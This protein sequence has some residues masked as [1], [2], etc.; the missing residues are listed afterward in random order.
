MENQR[1]RDIPKWFRKFYWWG[2]ASKVDLERDTKTIIVQLINHGAWSHWKWLVQTYGKEKLKN[3]I[4]EIPTSEFRSSALKLISL[5]LGIE[6]MKYASRSDY[7]KAKRNPQKAA[8][9]S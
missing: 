4:R 5:L 6:Q 8:N 1:P 2:D 9:P 3:I 7:I